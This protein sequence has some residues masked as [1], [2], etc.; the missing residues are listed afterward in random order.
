MGKES[1]QEVSKVAYLCKNGRKMEVYLD[2]LILNTY[3]MSIKDLPRIA[4]QPASSPLWEKILMGSKI[5]KTMQN[6]IM[7]SDLQYRTV[8]LFGFTYF[9]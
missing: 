5:T 2:T 9:I 7:Q 6:T 1:K 3:G 4:S 8:P